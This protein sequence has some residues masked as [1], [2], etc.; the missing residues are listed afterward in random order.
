MA[1]NPID[2]KAAGRR[3]ELLVLEVLRKYGPC[4]QAE[5][6]R[7]TGLGSS[8]SSYIVSRLREKHLINEQQGKSFRPGAKPVLVSINPGGCFV[9]GAEISPSSIFIVLFDFNCS[10]VDKIRIPL[11]NDLSVEN[12]VMLLEINLKGLISKHEIPQKKVLGIGV[13]LS[14]SISPDG[15]VELSSPMGWRSVPL[16][17]FL[18][19]K[20]DCSVDILTTRVRLLAEMYANTELASKNIVYMN[21]ANGVGCTGIIDGELIHGATNRSGELG[22]VIIDPD[23]PICGCGHKGCLEAFISG[24][25]IAKKIKQDID[26][27]QETILSGLIDADDTA[28]SMVTKWGRAIEQNDSYSLGIRKMVAAHMSRSAAIAINLYDP[29]VLI[30]A[31]YVCDKSPQYFADSV[32]KRFP[33][34]V[35]NETSRKIEVYHACAGQEALV[36]G[37][38]IAVLQKFFE[39]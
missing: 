33:T 27:G 12:V 32:K 1:R 7:L 34:D 30:L 35:Y 9:V 6:C 2:S 16:K 14:G 28:E 13:T 4:S 5:I 23:G 26:N 25:A 11:D 17:Q 29:D 37:A 36:T 19:Q 21:V 39:L 18:S 38:A 31:G 20:L 8:T 3:N 15:T 24:P 22:H 10:V